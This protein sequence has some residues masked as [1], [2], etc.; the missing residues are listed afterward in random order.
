MLLQWELQIELLPILEEKDMSDQLERFEEEEDNEEDM[1]SSAAASEALMDEADQTAAKMAK[2]AERMMLDT[3]S[4]T[5]TLSDKFVQKPLPGGADFVQFTDG[6]Q[7]VKCVNGDKVH[8]AKDGTITSTAKISVEHLGDNL[9]LITTGG[10]DKILVGPNGIAKFSNEKGTVVFEKKGAVN[11]FER[12]PNGADD[13]KEKEM[14]KKTEPMLE[15][16]KLEKKIVETVK[17]NPNKY[18]ERNLP[19][20][21]LFA[22]FEGGSQSFKFANGDKISVENGQVTA[23]ENLKVIY[24]KD[25]TT[26][27]TSKDGQQIMVGPEGIESARGSYGTIAFRREKEMLNANKEV[28]QFAQQQPQDARPR[29]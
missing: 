14:L 24:Q 23:S 12:Q 21:N 9:K 1:A 29:K 16:D 8:I 2:K 4:Q 27:I 6:S 19:G 5:V 11:A 3:D 25:G 26:L 7:S 10:G 15:G 28:K 22:Q 20:G 18:Q 13:Q 17:F